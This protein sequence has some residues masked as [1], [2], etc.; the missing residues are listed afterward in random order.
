MMSTSRRLSLVLVLADFLQLA[1]CSVDFESC[2]AEAQESTEQASCLL[3]A[4][5]R[6]SKMSRALNKD[7]CGEAPDLDGTNVQALI[8]NNE[9][10]MILGVDAMACTQAA[11]AAL[12]QK[13][14]SHVLKQFTGEFQYTKGVSDVWDWLHCKYSSGSPGDTHSG[15]I[16]H[17]YV[18]LKQQFLGEGFHAAEMIS[19]GSLDGQLNLSAGEPD[20]SSV[21]DA[22]NAKQVVDAVLASGPVVM[23]GWLGCPCVETAQTRFS[24]NKLCVKERTWANPSD[25]LMAYLQCKVGD[26]QSHSFIF[27]KDKSGDMKFIGNGFQFADEAMKDTE[28]DKLIS[29]ASADTSCTSETSEKKNVFDGPLEECRVGSDPMGSWLDDGTC[30]EEFGGIHQICLEEIP[31][32]FSAETGQS[33]W[34]EE[35]AGKRHCVCIGAWSLYMTKHDTNPVLP[36]CRSIPKTVF[37]SAY[38]QNW[39]DWNGIAADVQKGVGKL[40]EKC[41]QTDGITTEEKCALKKHF[42]ELQAQE[43]TLTTVHPEGLS[44]LQCQDSLLQLRRDQVTYSWHPCEDQ[45]CW[46]HGGS[47][48]VT[49]PAIPVSLSQQNCPTFGSEGLAQYYDQI[50]EHGNR[51]AASHLWAHFVLSH[52]EDCFSHTDLT[53]LFVQFCPVSGSPLGPASASNTY[54]Y[55]LPLA[56]GSGDAS[57]V[58]HHCCW[59]CSCDTSDL[60][61]VDTKSV[62]DKTG[63][64][65]QYKFLVIGDPCVHNP[66]VCTEA[67]DFDQ[68]IP[69][70]APDVVCEGNK[71]KNAEHSDGGHIIIGM[72]GDVPASEDQYV[73]FATALDADGNKLNE[74]CAAR[75]AADYDSGMG[76]IFQQVARINPIQ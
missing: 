61:K 39:K 71:L 34:S 2:Q 35:R 19:G 28:L 49:A 31:A 47:K 26:T 10:V 1:R 53:E 62:K 43:E 73:D 37:T 18:F 30:T 21:P 20:C 58:T 59:P 29:D 27:F 7:T 45:A 33:P 9:G 14:A 38:I 23:F 15:T 67:G 66:K 11:V 4:K 5:M 50:F 17:S 8:E 69:Q 3:Q 55:T 75:E 64:A 52:A 41:L 24:Q 42:E 40:V 48:P 70:E 68:C 46:N 57:G 25:P 36:H 51:N 32:D 6:H 63:L 44:G 13:R 76:A 56:D 54:K 22:E 72:F 16:M 74:A 60:I 65:K 12:N